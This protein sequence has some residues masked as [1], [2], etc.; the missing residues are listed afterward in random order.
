MTTT[1]RTCVILMCRKITYCYS[2]Y[3][4]E[5]TIVKSVLCAYTEAWFSFCLIHS[6]GRLYTLYIQYLVI[7]IDSKPLQYK[8]WPTL[9]VE[10]VELWY[11]Y[12]LTTIAVQTLANF[13]SRASRFIYNFHGVQK[14][15]CTWNL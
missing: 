9:K 14:G 3:Y 11:M 5:N 15:S 8:L 10:P 1:T 6:L 12:V 7:R 2:Y 4:L 13:K